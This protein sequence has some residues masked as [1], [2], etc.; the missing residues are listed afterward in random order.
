[1]DINLISE[2]ITEAMREAGKIML[3]ADRVERSV[4]EKAGSANFVTEY[5]VAVQNYLIDKISKL[6]PEAYFFAE[7]KENDVDIEQVKYCFVI[8]PIDGT[9]N[10]IN[11]YRRS[12]ISVALLCFGEAVFGAIYDPYQKE[13]F[14]AIAG[15]GAFLNGKPI[16]VSERPL[17]RAL[18]VFGTSP[19]H[20]PS[21]ANDTFSLAKELFLVANDLRR[22]GSAALDLANFAA[23]RSD[24][25]FECLLQLWDIAAGCLIVKEAGG[26]VTDLAGRPIS[27]RGASSVLAAS[28]HLRSSIL[29]ITEKYAR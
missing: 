29:K 15:K 3:S 21:L 19:Y 14:S 26:I 4:K 10:F 11:G 25:F 17:E 7:E 9:A 12:T 8:D 28:E 24:I 18:I 6:L 1:M 13:M 27:M 5:D 16:H 22:T 2:K 20:K 23:G